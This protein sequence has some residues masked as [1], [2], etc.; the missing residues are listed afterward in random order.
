[1]P[2]LTALCGLSAPAGCDG[3]DFAP[4]VRDEGDIARDAVLMANYSSHWDFF[5]TGT[6]WPEWR[7]VRTKQHTYIKWLTGKEE[8][9]DNVADAYQ[10]NNLAENRQHLSVL[11]K[12][13]SRLKELLAAADDKFL[14]GT[15]YADWYDD[16]RNLVRTALGPV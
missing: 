15:A 8:L 10:M 4:A 1:M 13:R 9:Y 14:P 2:T 3:V 6:K 16:Q 12:L 11:E 5:Q 7:A